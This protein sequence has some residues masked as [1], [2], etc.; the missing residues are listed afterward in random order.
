MSW[1][2]TPTY[3]L[4]LPVGMRF[5]KVATVTEY[6]SRILGDTVR[7]VAKREFEPLVRRSTVKGRAA[8]LTIR[9]M[10]ESL[11]QIDE[12]AERNGWTRA[13]AVR[14]LLRDGLAAQGNPGDVR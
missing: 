8:V 11:A 14:S 7:W 6:H 1:I 9:L 3:C 13:D 12:V 5:G 10:P 4:G 2:F